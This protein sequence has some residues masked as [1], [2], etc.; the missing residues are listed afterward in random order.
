MEQFEPAR[1]RSSPRK[2]GRI[3]EPP[4]PLLRGWL[5]GGGAIAA[6][7]TTIGLLIQPTVDLARFVAL[8]IFGMSMIVLYV[9]SSLYHLGTWTERQHSF[10]RAFDHANIFVFIA[11][12]YTPFCVIVL[13]GWLRVGMLVTIWALA[14]LGITFS[15]ISPHLPRWLMIALYSAMGWLSLILLPHLVE[16]I[17]LAPVLLLL[18][19]GALYTIGAV[20]YALR[21]PN[22]IP[23]LFGHHELF[24]L[25]VV[26]ATAL[27]TAALWI[28][29]VP[30][31]QR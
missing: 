14:V 15:L 6:I 18:A 27:I 19:G 13:T 30:F 23:W 16:A 9:V 11:G 8:A 4:K 10:L 3:G 2:P 21:W 7:A 25:L 20:I 1:R 12:A 28:W 17:S 29:V 26:C 31:V 5:H 24:H 22:P